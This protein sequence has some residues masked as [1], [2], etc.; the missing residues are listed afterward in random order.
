MK[1]NGRSSQGLTQN[2]VL[3]RKRQ[4]ETERQ[5]Q[6][7]KERER[8]RRRETKGNKHFT[9]MKYNGRPRNDWNLA[10]ET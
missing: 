7:K 2:I 5:R 8:K 9:K 1:Y 4:T 10:R 3:L 6:I